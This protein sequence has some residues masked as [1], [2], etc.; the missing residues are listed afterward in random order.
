M[1]VLHDTESVVQWHSRCKASEPRLV[2]TL[3]IDGEG[4][5]EEEGKEVEG[6]EKG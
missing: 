4:E 3:R 2:P 6:N 1:S 5:K